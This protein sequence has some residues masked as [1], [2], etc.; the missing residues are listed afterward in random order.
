MTRE[1][2]MARFKAAKERK[3]QHA[4]E[5]VEFLKNDYRQRTGKEAVSYEVW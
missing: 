1:E 4:M 3:R 2:A 5:L